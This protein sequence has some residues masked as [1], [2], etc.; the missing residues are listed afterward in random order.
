[1][2]KALLAGVYDP[3]TNATYRQAC[4]VELDRIGVTHHCKKTGDA[5]ELTAEFALHPDYIDR[6]Q[7]YRNMQRFW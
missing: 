4:T 2:I 5:F 7:V 6:V 1:M 3:N